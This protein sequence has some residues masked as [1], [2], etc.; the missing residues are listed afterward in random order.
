MKITINHVINWL[1]QVLFHTPKIHHNDVEVVDFRLI[2]TKWN[3]STTGSTG[4]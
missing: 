4:S 3:C 1:T 2:I